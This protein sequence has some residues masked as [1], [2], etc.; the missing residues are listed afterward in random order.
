MTKKPT[1][2]DAKLARDLTI[3]AAEAKSVKGGAI[4]R[5]TVSVDGESTHVDHKG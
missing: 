5:G 1:K 3:K 2:P 4:I